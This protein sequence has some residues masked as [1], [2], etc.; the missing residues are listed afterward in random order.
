MCHRCKEAETELIERLRKAA[1]NSGAYTPHHLVSEA[2]DEIEKLKDELKTVYKI[3]Q[4]FEN[5]HNEKR[6]KIEQLEKAGAEAVMEIMK[7]KGIM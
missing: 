6:D 3:A 2:A 1:N 4:L 7:L 5:S